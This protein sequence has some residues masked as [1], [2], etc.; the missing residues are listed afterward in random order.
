M[1]KNK[2]EAGSN[3]ASAS[4]LFPRV[5]IK[6]VDGVEIN[7]SVDRWSFAKSDG[8]D[9]IAIGYNKFTKLS[10]QSIYW[11]YKE[12]DFWV[13]GGA[14]AGYGNIPPEVLVGK[15][16]NHLSRSINFAPDLKINDIKLGHWW[17]NEPRRPVDG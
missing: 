5:K 15:D 16:D 2:A 8:I 3:F 7:I 11:V 14:P 12:E 10:G 9:E 17:I 1:N 6:Y 13:M 4:F